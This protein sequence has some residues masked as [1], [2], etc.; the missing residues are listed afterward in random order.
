MTDTKALPGFNHNDFYH[1]YL[2]RQVPSRCGRALDVGCGTGLFARRLARQAQSVDA[3]DSAPEVI[4]KARA[5]SGGMPNIQ[6]TA[7][8]LADFPLSGASYDFIACL[9]SIH[10]MPFAGTVTTLRD[11]LTPGGVLAVLGC[12][13]YSTPRDYL[14]DLVAAPTNLVASLTVRAKARIGSR[15]GQVNTAPVMDPPMT[16]PEIRSEASRLLPG[17]V[18]RRLLFWRYSL[19]YRDATDHRPRA[20]TSSMHVTEEGPA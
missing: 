15:T 1:R 12:F 19:I 20:C 6:Y 2:L 18:I 16:L 10:H 3:I 9:A 5:L 17:V 7:A 11:A 8:D 4:V 14:P 13:R